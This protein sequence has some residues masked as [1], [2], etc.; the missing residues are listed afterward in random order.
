MGDLTAHISG[1][2][3]AGHHATSVSNSATSN[4]VS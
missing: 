1:G 3:G 2:S 4:A